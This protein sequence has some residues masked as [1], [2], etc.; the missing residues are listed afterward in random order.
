MPSKGTFFI[1]SNSK[2]FH[3]PKLIS[4]TNGNYILE[5]F[6]GKGG[7]ATVYKC[8]DEV[9]GNEFAV[10]ILSNDSGVRKERF[11]KELEYL[12][13]IENEYIVDLVD[14]GVLHG[15]SHNKQLKEFSFIVLEYSSSGNLKDLFN[16]NS[17]IKEELYFSQFRGLSKALAY[18]HSKNILHRDIKPENILVIEDRW[19]LCDFGLA[20][21]TDRNPKTDLTK[22]NEKIGPMFWMSPEAI[23]QCLLNSDESFPKICKSS[24]VFQLAS[25]FWFIIN[26][27][28]P[29][30]ILTEDDWK[31][32][33]E[34]FDVLY[35]AL[36]N[37]PSERYVDGEEFSKALIE[38]IE[39]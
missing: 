11:N 29:S 21:S 19:V 15:R 36:Y 23:N 22:E 6:I 7:N 2:F 1:R 33:K 5:E 10:K 34:I 28:H 24:D 9:N 20:S 18:V 31:G 4:A 13:N 30:G 17:R 39:S 27:R 16:I 25:V 38:A 8:N 3:F 35:K 14:F 12:K 32:K 37:N 26:K